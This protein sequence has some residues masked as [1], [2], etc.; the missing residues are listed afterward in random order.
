[1][2]DLTIKQRLLA[3]MFTLMFGLSLSIFTDMSWLMVTVGGVIYQIID[4]TTF[5][6][7]NRK[8]SNKDEN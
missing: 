4:W 2:Y 8:K 7:L 3:I 5:Q 1:M 6:I